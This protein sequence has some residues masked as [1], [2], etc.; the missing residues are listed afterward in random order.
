MKN[1]TKTIV[2][3][4]PIYN[5]NN[6]H[7][8]E[9]EPKNTIIANHIWPQIYKAA[10]A[11]IK[12]EG[13][14]TNQAQFIS[15]CAVKIMKIVSNAENNDRSL[16]TLQLEYEEKEVYNKLVQMGE[17]FISESDIFQ[18]QYNTPSNKGSFVVKNA[19]KDQEN[20]KNL[21]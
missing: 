7:D 9:H 1:Y 20:I 18:E 4:T 12:H 6:A 8:N 15:Q 5:W 14:D 10:Q 16:D 19:V 21:K 17:S 3:W 11:L 13:S 2:T